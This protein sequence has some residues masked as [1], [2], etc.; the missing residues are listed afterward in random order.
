ME[1]QNKWN[2]ELL[3]SAIF[4]CSGIIMFLLQPFLTIKEFFNMLPVNILRILVNFG[5]YSIFSTASWVV[6]CL[7]FF[8]CSIYLGV[9]SIIKAKPIASL[10]AYLLILL[11]S[12][13]FLWLMVALLFFT[14][15]SP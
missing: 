6:L 10:L 15:V 2:K 9:L 7:F 1:N 5:I 3:Y 8:L 12:I 13:A 4:L 14:T 11:S